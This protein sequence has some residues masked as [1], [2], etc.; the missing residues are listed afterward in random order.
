MRTAVA[1]QPVVIVAEQHNHGTDRFGWCI[2]V[3]M[4]HDW[5]QP[6]V[7]GNVTDALS[8]LWPRAIK[9]LR[10][11]WTLWPLHGEVS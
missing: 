8:S 3:P 9:P 4:K 6:P 11:D 5:R 1:P 7:N 2:D 10:N